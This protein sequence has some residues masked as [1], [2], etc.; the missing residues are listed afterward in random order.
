MRTDLVKAGTRTPAGIEQV[1]SNITHAH[2]LFGST[3]EDRT[4]DTAGP[5]SGSDGLLYF[6]GCIVRYWL[7]EL[8]SQTTKILQSAGLRWLTLGKKEW[9]CGTPLLVTGRITL[10]EKV[11]RHNLGLLEKTGVKRVVTSCPGCY[12]TLKYDNPT[13]EKASIDVLHV[14]ELLEELIK[15]GAIELIH[16]LPEKVTYHDPCELGRRSRIF[17][18]PREIFS[19]IK[20]LDLREMPRNREE[21]LC[22]GGGGAV[23][24][25]NPSLARRVT[26]ERLEEARRLGVNKIVSCCPS[27]KMNFEEAIASASLPLETLDL[28]ELVAMAMRIG[29]Q[30]KNT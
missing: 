3:E 24:A 4:W 12:R 22:C 23:K 28:T 29:D 17:D 30:R 2:N 14:T 13:L 9:C 7:P 18:A 15:K 6:P 21:A 20:G 5:A 26:I 19:R 16:S 10:A 25:S 11:S 27:C 1:V 8:A